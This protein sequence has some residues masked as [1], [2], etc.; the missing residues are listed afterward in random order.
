M[1]TTYR[2]LRAGRSSRRARWQASLATSTEDEQRRQAEG[3]GAAEGERRLPRCSPCGARTHGDAAAA[4]TPLL[5]KTVGAAPVRQGPSV[6]ALD[7]L[8]FDI[9][10]Y[11]M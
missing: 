3:G 5:R 6:H 8:P 1:M 10:V 11:S 9:W 2:R 7:L 4:S